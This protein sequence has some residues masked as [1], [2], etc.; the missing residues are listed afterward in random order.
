MWYELLSGIMC[1]KGMDR[2]VIWVLYGF[3]E[4]TDVFQIKLSSLTTAFKKCIMCL[5]KATNLD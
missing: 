4:D 1:A 5:N 3:I 2:W